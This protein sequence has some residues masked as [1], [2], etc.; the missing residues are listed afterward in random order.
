MEEKLKKLFGE[1]D[2]FTI[3]VG[4]FSTSFSITDKTSKREIGKDRKELNKTISIF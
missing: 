2:G 1:I 3:L 4:D